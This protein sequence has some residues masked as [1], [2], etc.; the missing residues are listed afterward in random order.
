MNE[1]LKNLR[2]RFIVC[3]CSR[4]VNV[5][6]CSFLDSDMV[7]RSLH[8]LNFLGVSV[9]NESQS[10][11]FLFFGFLLMIVG[12][13]I[14]FAMPYTLNSSYTYYNAYYQRNETARAGRFLMASKSS[15]E[16][17]R[18]FKPVLHKF[19][20]TLGVDDVNSIIVTEKG[21]RFE[22]KFEKI[23]F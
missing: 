3:L 11:I 18:I 17:Y 22:N 8:L 12:T 10:A 1:I 7:N 9:M 14:A 2:V 21:L 13:V 19:C 5:I 23:K 6:G 16:I 15:K 4:E 20:E